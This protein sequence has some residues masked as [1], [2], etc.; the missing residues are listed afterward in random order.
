M[1]SRRRFVLALG[2]GALAVP[3]AGVAQ[4]P[5][6]TYRIGF[7]A[8]ETPSDPSQAKRL[9]VLRSALRQLGYRESENIVID[10]RW[11]EGQYDRL[12]SLAAELVAR[13]VNV[14]VASGTK[15]TVAASKATT[16]IPIVMGSTGDPIGLGLTTDLARPSANVTGRTNFGPELGPKLCEALKEAVPSIVRMAY[17]FN[18]ADPPT[19][20]P[21]MQS[22][23]KALKLELRSFEAGTSKQFDG[24]FTEM[25][26]AQSHAVVVQGDTLFAVN[27]ESIARLALKHRLPSAS[28]LNDFAEVGG[29]MTYGPDRLEGFR[30]A[31]FFA[32]RLLKG[33]KP[34]DLPIERPTKFELV[35]NMKTAKALGVAIPQSLLLRAD[36]VVE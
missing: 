23:A 21:G 35:V 7:L 31:A 34:G 20:F 16:T 28:S 24:A 14:I 12:P 13:R 11:A 17:L 26:K 27:V 3:F 1:R 30:R 18:P 9:E 8:S 15:A 25:V 10:A 32:D 5:A 4:Q 19:T 33:A 29:L 2:A 36:T 22:A 6:K